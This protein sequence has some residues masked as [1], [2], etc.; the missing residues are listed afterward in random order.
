[1]KGIKK[2]ARAALKQRMNVVSPRR[3]STPE[4][5]L[6]TSALPTLKPVSNLTLRAQ[7]TQS[8]RIALMNRNL[9]P[10]QAVTVKAI[11][12]MLG[13]RVMPAREAMTRL[14]A[15]GALELRANRTVIVPHL[16]PQDF[17]EL[18]DLSC[19]IECQ[20][21]KQALARIGPHHIAEL[22]A[23]ASDMRRQRFPDIY[24]NANFQFHFFD[25]RLG[26]SSFVL[27]IIE[28]MGVR[29][30]PLIRFGLGEIDFSDSRRAH[31]RIIDGLVQR[32]AEGLRQA[33]HD[34]L[35]TAARII[36][37]ARGWPCRHLSTAPYLDP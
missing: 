7:V 34:D 1:M 37:L 20:A 28:N 6:S 27:G 21:A 10:G 26:T 3:M 13:A 30:G 4:T 23:I 8:V 25:Y 14:I 2:R 11:L 12:G 16:S 17:D 35:T 15:M 36:R 5:P 22:C 9:Q 19:H 32:D 31:A 33:I 24:L 18:T 29:L